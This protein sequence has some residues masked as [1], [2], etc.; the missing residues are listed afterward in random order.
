MLI[1]NFF[2]LTNRTSHLENA[3]GVRFRIPRSAYTLHRNVAVSFAVFSESTVAFKSRNFCLIFG[4]LISFLFSFQLRMSS[5]A[6]LCSFSNNSPFQHHRVTVSFLSVRRNLQSRTAAQPVRRDET[7]TRRASIGMAPRQN[8]YTYQLPPLPVP[9]LQQ[10]LD[11]Y[12]KSLEPLLSD[13]E[14]Q[15][16]QKV[17]LKHREICFH[18]SARIKHGP[19]I[20]TGLMKC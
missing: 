6:I 17:R 18:F 7:K 13:G 3:F 5:K 11:K 20:F 9:P 1:T 16:T 2:P 12:T 10:T 8:P 15:H 4:Y 19:H 14:L